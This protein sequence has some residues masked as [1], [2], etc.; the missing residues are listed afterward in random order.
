MSERTTRRHHFCD[1]KLQWDTALRS[2]SSVSIGHKSA[3]SLGVAGSKRQ[4]TLWT[5]LHWT[6]SEPSQWFR[7]ALFSIYY[8]DELVGIPS[9]MLYINWVI[10]EEEDWR[11]CGVI[12]QIHTPLLYVMTLKRTLFMVD[13]NT[14]VPHCGSVFHPKWCYRYG[15]VKMYTYF[16][17]L[18]EIYLNRVIFHSASKTSLSGIAEA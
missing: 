9:Q 18:V 8:I 1:E 12:L 11:S 15:C 13:R 3:L 14:T 6:A 10:S 5:N 17:S 4:E 16:M 2:K 7:A